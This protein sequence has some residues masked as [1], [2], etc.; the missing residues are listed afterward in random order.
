MR[1][2]GLLG[3][4]AAKLPR[5]NG[6]NSFTTR[7]TTPAR[8]AARALHTLSGMPA[9]LALIAPGFDAEKVLELAAE[10]GTSEQM[11]FSVAVDYRVHGLNAYRDAVMIEVFRFSSY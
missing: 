7:V 2:A 3:N 8:I 1:R 9:K 6:A 4:E 11:L 10:M 5:R